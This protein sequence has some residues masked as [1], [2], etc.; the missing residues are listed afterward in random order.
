MPDHAVQHEGCACDVNKIISSI[1]GCFASG[2]ARMVHARKCVRVGV[3][4]AITAIV[5]EDGL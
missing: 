4:T 3:D 1:R 5:V 2:E